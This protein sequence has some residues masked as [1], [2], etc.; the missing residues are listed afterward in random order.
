MDWPSTRVLTTGGASFIES[1]LA[2]A[3]VARGAGVRVVHD[4]SS[5]RQ[6]NTKSHVDSLI[7]PGRRLERGG[8]RDLVFHTNQAFAGAPLAGPVTER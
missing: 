2:D 3:L 1:H 4:P 5:D 8:N 7:G 6:A